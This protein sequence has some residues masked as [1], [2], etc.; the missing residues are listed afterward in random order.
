MVK[1]LL[2]LSSM[3]VLGMFSFAQNVQTHYD[4]GHMIYDEL[5]GESPRPSFTTTVEMFRPDSWGS[6][7]FFI[8]MD[9][10]GGVK[11]AYWEIAR[12]ICFWQ[13][14]KMNWLSAHVEY[15]GG[16]NSLMSF[17]NAYLV[18]ATYSGHSKDFSKTWSLSVMYKNIPNTVGLDGN[19]SVHNFQVTGVWG[20]HMLD[21]WLSFTGFIDFW[22]EARP[23]QGTDY[24]L[25]S[26]PQIWVNLNKIPSWD[27]VN[28]S[29]GG[30]VELSNNFV[31]KGFYA[32]PTVA[33]KWTF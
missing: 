14:S 9:Y 17:N 26:E 5:G 16:M 33:A 28:L 12:E 20:I 6:T 25:I 3:L 24:I 10:N 21:N 13:N 23:W 22:K 18:G 29:I 27:K 8:D 4:F 2:L 19:A 1:R 7:F 31:N 32:I 11:G 15:N 30:E